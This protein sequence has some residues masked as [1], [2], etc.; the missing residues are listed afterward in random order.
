MKPLNIFLQMFANKEYFSLIKKSIISKDIDLRI[1]ADDTAPEL[2]NLW[3]DCN[4]DE[5]KELEEFI[6]NN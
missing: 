2:H 1:Q 6:L 3:F 4:Q 5:I